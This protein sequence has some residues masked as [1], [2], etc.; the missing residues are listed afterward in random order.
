MFA[1]PLSVTYRVIV[2]SFLTPKPKK[3]FLSRCVTNL[4]YFTNATYSIQTMLSGLALVAN[5]LHRNIRLTINA[6]KDSPRRNSGIK[7]IKNLC[8]WKKVSHVNILVL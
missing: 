5:T 3:V 8:I 4:N 7:T 6:I 1:S 2:I